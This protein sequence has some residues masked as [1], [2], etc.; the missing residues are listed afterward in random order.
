MGKRGV[1]NDDEIA[2]SVL[3]RSNLDAQGLSSRD[4]HHLLA[5]GSLRRVRRGWYVQDRDPADFFAEQRHLRHMHAVAQ[6]MR[7]DGAAFS[8]VS[9][10]VA[11]RLPLRRADTQRVHLTMRGGRGA[12]TTTDLIRHR[13]RLSDE[14]VTIV[15]GLI[16]TSLPRTVLDVARTT[17]PETALCVADAAL[18][19]IAWRERAHAYDERAAETFRGEMAARLASAPGG[20]GVARAR[21]IVEAMDGRAQL[22]GESVSRLMLA[23][24]GFERPRLQV[25]IAGPHQRNYFVDFGLDDACAWGEFDGKDKFRNPAFLAGRTPEEALWDEKQREDWIRGTTGRP[26]IRWAWEHISSVG[27]F[28]RRL[29]SFGIIAPI[30]RGAGRKPPR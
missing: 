4:I 22:P 13:D 11:H 28:E 23:Q 27:T 3:S 12:G 8:H 17:S 30:R 9:A 25:P 18:R 21:R 5:A 26:V 16:C 2:L 7:G 6:A 1:M 24:L 14:D 20:R 19:T 15:G 29:R 10:A